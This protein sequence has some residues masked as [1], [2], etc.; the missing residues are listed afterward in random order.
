VLAQVKNN[1]APPQ[2]SLAYEMQLH[3]QGP[4]SIHW[5]GASPWSAAQLLA[6]AAARVAAPQRDRARDFLNAFLKDGP[7]NS[8]EVWDAAR[9]QGH[10]EIT[11]RRTARKIPVDFRRVFCDGV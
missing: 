3:E 10:S 7:R 6:A 9:K 2:P 5:L 4:P 8:H 11:V 1:L